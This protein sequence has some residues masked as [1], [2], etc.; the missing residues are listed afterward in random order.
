MISSIFTEKNGNN[1]LNG[2][3]Q[4]RGDKLQKGRCEIFG[5]NRYGRG[6]T[7][8]VNDLT[9][10]ICKKSCKDNEITFARCFSDLD[11]RNCFA[12]K[13]FFECKHLL[14]RERATLC[15]DFWNDTE[16]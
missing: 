2:E 11:C 14:Q 15:H 5:L 3:L 13:L 9:N 16:F 7:A 10:V 1:Q 6:A 12:S 4:G 8:K